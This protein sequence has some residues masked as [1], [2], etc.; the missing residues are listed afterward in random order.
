MM[1]CISCKW[2]PPRW[3]WPAKKLLQVSK[4][5]SESWFWKRI[6]CFK[7]TCAAAELVMWFFILRCPTNSSKGRDQSAT[8]NDACDTWQDDGVR[9]RC[10]GEKKGGPEGHTVNCLGDDF[11]P[12]VTCLLRFCVSAFEIYIAFEIQSAHTNHFNLYKLQSIFKLGLFQSLDPSASDTCD[13]IAWILPRSVLAFSL[14]LYHG[15][16]KGHV[17]HPPWFDSGNPKIP[18]K[19]APQILQLMDH[20]DHIHH[21]GVIEGYL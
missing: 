2:L 19:S 17:N 18:E 1:T 15:L 20:I 3:G 11:F 13:P 9:V 16:A 4:F 21:L 12:E 8:A 6:P 10:C 5:P 14:S 7:E